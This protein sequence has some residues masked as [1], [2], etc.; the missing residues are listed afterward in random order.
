MK[1]LQ[2]TAVSALLASGVCARNSHSHKHLESL[3]RRHKHHA[4]PVTSRAETGLKKRTTCAFPTDAG[5]TPVTPD[6]ANGGWAMSPDQV[7]VAD[8]YCPYACPPG[9][10]M[11]QWNPDSS[12]SDTS[13]MVR[14]LV[15]DCKYVD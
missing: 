4:R 6:D 1:L 15:F 14:M 2:L 10:M 12:Y 13:R 5:L 9:Q 7:C 11:A 8:S 3:E